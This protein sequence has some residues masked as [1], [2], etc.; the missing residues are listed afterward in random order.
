MKTTIISMEQL[1][2]AIN[3]R[4]LSNPADGRH[5][6]QLILNDILAALQAAWGCEVVT[7]RGNPIVSISD[8][9]D[10]LHYPVDGASRD[11][12]YSRYVCE[13]AL[14]RTQ[15]SAMVPRAMQNVA[16]N[17]PNDV[18]LACPGMVYRRDSVDRIHS[19]EPHHLDLWRL[20]T[21]APMTSAILKETVA[22]ILNAALPNVEWKLEHSPH[23][24][25][26]EGVEI[27]AKCDGQW[28]EVGECGL[29]HPDIIRENI[30]NASGVTGLALGMG[31]DR[32]LMVRKGIK[33]IRLLRST[34][35]RVMEQ[36]QDLAPYRDVSSMPP[37]TRDLSIVRDN[38]ANNED[39]GD[40][41]REA[42]GPQAD[43]V[44]LVEMISETPYASLPPQAMRRLGIVEG[45]KN[46]LLRVVLRA[47]E[48]TMTT[49][50]C[51]VHRDTIYKA[52]HQG[53]VWDLING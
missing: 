50:E 48:R 25:T 47:L 6:M 27:N 11:A 41:V 45:Q 44:E 3:L 5:A 9:Y 35:P 34:D 16:E 29:A 14:L 20:T 39:L 18:L 15:M 22:I 10:C 17:M 4:D 28:V 52:L 38:A 8:N 46:I 23:P 13:T 36:M 1:R 53:T 21:K 24:Y 49:E 43:I 42:L 40:K 33:D 2:H 19:A 7:Y 30:P 37:V 12:R 26:L 31:L 32:L 51:N